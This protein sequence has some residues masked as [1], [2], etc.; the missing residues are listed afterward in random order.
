[1][2]KQRKKLAVIYHPDKKGG[3]DSMMQDINSAVDM[4][5]TIKVQCI[6]PSWSFSFDFET[7]DFPANKSSWRNVYSSKV[8]S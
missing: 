1:M 3:D 5:L 4:L 6:E 8:W 7:T 2:K